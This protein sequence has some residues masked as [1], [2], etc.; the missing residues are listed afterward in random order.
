MVTG[1]VALLMGSRK[2][3]GRHFGG[4]TLALPFDAKGKCTIL[5]VEE[6]CFECGLRYP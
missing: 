2:T 6:I 1:S 5:R 3:C 4:S